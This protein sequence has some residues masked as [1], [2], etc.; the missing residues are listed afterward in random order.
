MDD[1]PLP[2][3]GARE[4]VAILPLRNSVL[5]PMSVV[6]I[7]VGRPRSVRLVE[8]FTGSERTLVGVIA[9]RDPE[10]V[11]P[12]FEDLYEVG[13]LAR[14]VKV[15]RLGQANYSVVLNGLGR[16]RV[17]RPAGFEPYMR[18][19]VERLR[20]PRGAD[21]ELTQLAHDLRTRMRQ[22]LAMLP[23]LPK[24]TAGILDNVSEPGALADLIASNF[25]EEHAKVSERQSVLEA[26]DTKERVK[27]VKEI[28]DRQLR[29]LRVKDEIADQI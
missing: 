21:P 17:V 8:E 9:Q 12:T 28:V 3:T 14:V 7:N 26:L 5:L 29:V 2:A 11:E 1:S 23:E 15:I 16:F 24:E 22:V 10:V 20:E 18:A 19:D 27:L 13:T 25:P 4:K 6:P